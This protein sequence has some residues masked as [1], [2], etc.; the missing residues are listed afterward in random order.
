MSNEQ[1]PN[2]LQDLKERFAGNMTSA[3]QALYRLTQAANLLTAQPTQTS[4]VTYRTLSPLADLLFDSGYYIAYVPQVGNDPI[5]RNAFSAQKLVPFL[6]DAND[7]LYN[8]QN[9]LLPQFEDV[10][11]IR[12]YLKNDGRMILTSGPMPMG[13]SDSI[14]NYTTIALKKI[15]IDSL[16][17]DLTQGFSLKV[18]L[19][20]ETDT[21][22]FMRKIIGQY[23]V[24]AYD[25]QRHGALPTRTPAQPLDG[26]VMLMN[27]R[28]MQNRFRRFDPNIT[29]QN[30]TFL[31]KKYFL[32]QV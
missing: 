10:Q 5:R 17:L 29:I 25:S 12:Q 7:R 1:N 15:L 31:D 6:D 19:V 2:G 3:N 27:T 23:E 32:E 18:N 30:G 24:E 9:H 8:G 21:W 13:A 14:L 16:C 11:S 28:E 22:P 26:Y 20:V 4:R